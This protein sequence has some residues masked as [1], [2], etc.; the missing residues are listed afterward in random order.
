LTDLLT[1]E[2]L[3]ALEAYSAKYGF[4]RLGEGRPALPFEGDVEDERDPH[5]ILLA[6]VP[7]LIAEVRRYRRPV[8]LMAK[9]LSMQQRAEELS[10]RGDPDAELIHDDANNFWDEAERSIRRAVCG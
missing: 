8:T 3:L 4:V 9:A 7:Y 6:H 5:G 1:D 2:D 10:R